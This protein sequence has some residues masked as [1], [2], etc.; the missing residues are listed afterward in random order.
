MLESD[1]ESIELTN[2]IR[3]RTSGCLGH[4][5]TILKSKLPQERESIEQAFIYGYN[6]GCFDSFSQPLEIQS[7]PAAEKY[8][9]DNFNN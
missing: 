7:L 1:I 8:Y 2:N 5:V 6:T 4:I 9:D 3:I